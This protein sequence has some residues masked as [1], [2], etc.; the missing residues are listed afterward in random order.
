M[1][2]KK[3]NYFARNF[4][5]VRTELIDYVKHFYPELYQ[6]F[7]DA[8]IGTMLIE[9]NAATADMLSYHTDRMFNE[10]QIDYAQERRSLMNI[11]RTLG[12]KI[13]GKRS[14]I[15]L[16]DFIVTVPV[17]GD[18]FDV[19]YAPIIR[20]GAQVAGGGQTFETLDDI[21][22]SSP[23]SSGGIPNRL[24]VPI[25]NS[26]NQITSYNLV[27]REIVSNG[28]SKIFKRTLGPNDAVPFL[29]VIL[30]DNNVVSIESVITKEG[31]TFTGV[32]TLSDFVNPNLKWYEV[33]SLAEDKVFLP[34]PTRSTDNSGIIPGKWVNVTRKFL[35]EYTDTGFCKITFGSGFSDEQY[36]QSYTNDQYILQIANFFNSTALGEVPRPNST[37]FVRYRVGGGA[38]AN[39]GANVINAVGQFEMIING[40]TPANNQAVRNSLRV[41]NPVPAFGG[42][43]DPTIEEVRYMTKYNFASQ[44]RAVTIKDYVATIFKMPGKYGVPFRMQ[45]AENQNKVEFAV[46]GLDSAGKLSNSSTNTL[47]ENMATWLA[48]YRMIN[49]Y[50]LIRDGKIINLAFQIDLFTEKSFNQGEII[51]NAINVVKDYFDVKKWQ[52]GQNIYISQLVEAL[53]NVAGVLNVVDIK[54]FNR[55][56]GNYSLNATSQAYIDDTT[57]EINLTDDYVLFAEY[58]TMF[59]IKFPNTDIKVRTKS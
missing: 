59:E 4:L 7:N 8:S 55:V 51:N 31:T 26:N 50:V 37:M 25:I 14:S 53:N 16:V 2:E 58:D 33:D 3:I 19:R 15:T 6:D 10:T 13:P 30:P 27:K 21:D 43:D 54:I 34:D 39:I 36:L 22:F 42:A 9:L 32:P 49:D 12:L 11:A 40:P 23:F 45:V 18:T 57:R 24:I 17:F 56:G 47:K 1:A 29:E 28:V 44:N 35:K 48:D 5:D 46:L 20:Y 52:M 38:G 41:N